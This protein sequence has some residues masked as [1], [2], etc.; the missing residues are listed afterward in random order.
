MSDLITAKNKHLTLEQRIEIQDCLLHGM[1]F[2]AI[3]RRIG[4]DPTTVSKEVKRNLTVKQVNY[5]CYDQY[6]NQLSPQPC[7]KLLK[8]PFVCNSCE[9]RTRNCGFEKHHYYAR[10]AQKAY[11][12]TLKES[13]EG[14]A[15]N[16][17][18]FW[19][20]DKV[21]A[22][23]IK[24]GQRL[25]H[26]MQTHNLGVSKSTVYRHLHQGYLSS[27]PIDFPR[28]VKFKPR[29]K[30]SDGFIPKAAKIGRLY[31]DFLAYT[32][33][34]NISA[35]VELDTLIGRIGGKVILTITF[36]LYN[37]QV[38][39]LMDNKSAA[40]TSRVICNLK[41]SFTSAEVRFGDIIPL[42]LTDNGGEFANIMDIENN[43]AGQRETMLFFCDPYQSSQ[44]A[45]CEKNHTEFRNI[46][47]TGTSF[48][49]YSQETVNL[50][51]SHVNSIKRK[52]LNGRTPYELFAFTFG[53]QIASLFGVYPVSP[54]LVVQ[55]P[56]LLSK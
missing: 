38:G 47:P 55:S 4:K 52:I 9:K 2:K 5:Q 54:E 18:S 24:K 31:S 29:R 17:Q 19:E 48:D 45:H 35:W 13:R 22:E 16:K 37:F 43:A 39:L 20:I 8:A 12:V 21:I 51:F 1:T 46:V 6:G 40:E 56:K 36:T 25:Y 50:I 28:V 41:R 49:N 11:E 3:A 34:F 42:A 44:K 23:G 14:I 30:R 26:I 33:E 27:K 15:L 10:H 53:E 7:P 32:K